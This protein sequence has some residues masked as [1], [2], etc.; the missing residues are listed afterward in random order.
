MADKT[1]GQAA[2]QA[3]MRAQNPDPQKGQDSFRL[4]AAG[5]AAYYNGL[6][7]HGTPQALAERLAENLHIQ[8]MAKMNEAA[9]AHREARQTIEKSLD[10][11]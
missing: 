3:L 4:M 6:I 9:T 5:V 1:F 2:A 7:E 8:L 10:G 11:K